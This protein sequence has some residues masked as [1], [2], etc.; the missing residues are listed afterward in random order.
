MTLAPA[1]TEVGAV[2]AGRRALLFYVVFFVGGM[3]ALMYQVTWQRVL[4]LYF[5][6]DIYSTSVTVATFLL[7]LGLGSLIGGWLA[8]RTRRP[9]LHYAVIE[10]LMGAFGFLSVPLF[11]AVGGWLGG[12]PLAT[13]V[14]VDFALL[15]I[16]TTLMGMT[17]PLMCRVVIRSDAT[18]GRHLSWLYGVNTLGAAAGALLS[19]YL[20]IGVLGL[21]GTTRLAAWLNAAA[22]LLVCLAAAVNGPA[23]LENGEGAWRDAPVRGT[24]ATTQPPAERLLDYRTVLLFS[25]VSG[26]TALGYEIVW[27]RVLGILLHGTVYVFGTILFFYLAGMAA[28][29]LLARRHIDRGNCIRRFVWC[30]FGIAAYVFAMFS[31]LGHF[32]WVPGLRHVTAASFF[33]SFHPSP[34]LVSGQLDVF[35]LYSLLD[36][37]FWSIAILGVPTVLMGYGFPNLIREGSRDLGTIGHSISGVYFANIAGST[38]GSLLIGFG[39]IH[40]FGSENALRLLIVTGALVPVVLAVKLH[41][42][43]A[44]FERRQAYVPLGLVILTALVFPG[45]TQILEAIHFAAFETVDF[46]AAEDRSGVSALRRQHQPIAFSQEAQI[47]GEERLYIDGAHH[48]D[49]STTSLVRDWAVD[50]VL[51]AHRSPRRVLAIGLGD[52]QMAA[53]AV[54]WPEVEEVVIVELN[55]TLSGVLEETVP[56][57]TVLRSPKT[58]L[59]VDDGRR[60]LLANPRERFDV[61]MM[62]PLHAA[63]AHSGALYSREFLEIAGRH[64]DPGGLLLVRSVDLFSTA[65]TIATVFPHVLRLEGSVYLAGFTRFGW[66]TER[67][68][69]PAADLVA[70]IEADGDLIRART[71]GARLNTDFTLNS[72]YYITY[73]FAW[74]LQT[75]GARPASYRADHP[76][77]FWSFVTGPGEAE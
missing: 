2:R 10:L 42:P 76:Q 73:P 3:P 58:R 48:G 61:I 53:T 31:I 65:R 57:A 47:S 44:A 55:S 34:E 18:I 64:L 40:Y 4:T 67:L 28:G 15:L 66:R 37:V 45:R 56:G 1:R 25:F 69:M 6:V 43:L 72:E 70:R 26:F 62:F 8:D 14:V 77:R 12:S 36:L 59:E 38:V 16:P 32:S 68:T 20:L 75:R 21:D 11:A 9:V 23:A 27:Y 60:W 13:V 50:A 30:Q 71:E 46:T 52:A 19:A 39:V 22:A 74:T 49:A 63:H 17:L 7:G 33:T 5:G 24:A 29:S 51:A 35:A 41:G 54:L